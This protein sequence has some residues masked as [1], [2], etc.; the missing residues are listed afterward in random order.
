MDALD[1]VDFP[2]S[3]LVSSSPDNA[4]AP[5]PPISCDDE[6]EA[7]MNVVEEFLR[8]PFVVDEE[9]GARTPPLLLFLRDPSETALSFGL[10]VF[11]ELE[12]CEE[13]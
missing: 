5:P 1:V 8:M 11:L 10:S 3:D 4:A 7:P 2:A 6:D 9:D 12:I 13:D